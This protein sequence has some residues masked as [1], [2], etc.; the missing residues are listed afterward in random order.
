[1]PD[2]G[3]LEPDEIDQWLA[4]VPEDD[5]PD[6]REP[7]RVDPFVII[8]IVL[9]IVILVGMIL[10]RPT[11]AS[12]AQSDDL[13]ALGIPTDF[14]RA[15][16][17]D[18]SERPCAG[19]D[20]LVCKAVQFEITD[21]PEEGFV[22][23]QEFPPAASM[24]ELA[25]GDGVV[26]SRVTPSG[27]VDEVVTG[28]CSFDPEIQCVSL[29]LTIDDG[30]GGREATYELFPGDEAVVFAVGDEAL[31]D[32]MYDGDQLEILSVRPADPQSLY[33][34]ADFDRRMVLIVVA[35]AFAVVVVLLGG[36]RGATALVGL[37]ASVTILLMFVLPAILD[38]R[39]PVLVAVF[40]SAAIAYVAMYLAHGVNRMTTIALMGMT[41]SLVLTALLSAVVVAAA[42]FT[43]F[44]VEETSL[45]TFF[46][47]ID[48]SGLLLAGI[49]L[50]AAG[51]L[52]DVTITQAAM[53]WELQETNPTRDWRVHFRGALRVGRDH[54]A[55]MVNTL[56]LAYAGAS[57]PLLVLFVV[58]HQSLG[59]IANSEV[60]AVEI[61]RTL[62]GSI[63]L[64]AAVPLTTW[65]AAR[66]YHADD[67]STAGLSFR[68][69]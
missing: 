31:V 12:Q 49:V 44:A 6:D 24:P 51:A 63:G 34:F 32:F 59:T 30:E 16:V 14:H 48:V 10:L 37:A 21:G 67:G 62:V 13:T 60:V 54:I 53:V 20:S 22:F 56:L 2:S 15:T 52:D 11:G 69:S 27:T 1:M 28:P 29:G 64:V 61:V 40:G 42:R 57:L 19:L 35:L 5:E 18:V 46:G 41:A 39:S 23:F 36:W 43:G 7:R 58:A 25:P 65:L 4:F 68:R 26:L 45:L 9:G 66:F 55:S 3:A 17:L 47:G 50:G 8:G 33:Q 38:G